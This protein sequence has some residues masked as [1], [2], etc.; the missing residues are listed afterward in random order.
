MPP[1]I[2]WI[3]L[4]P[5][6]Q[7]RQ[8]FRKYGRHTHTHIQMHTHAHFLASLLQEYTVLKVAFNL[9]SWIII[10]LPQ[11]LECPPKNVKCTGWSCAK[12]VIR[13]WAPPCT[14]TSASHWII[15]LE[16]LQLLHME[17]NYQR[18]IQTSPSWSTTQAFLYAI[19]NPCIHEKQSETIKRLVST[20][21]EIIY[22]YWHFYTDCLRLLAA[23][24]A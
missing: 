10:T 12:L 7:I 23:S 15:K 19:Y 2:S 17:W 16:K 8:D 5:P 24:W 21:F 6:C 9:I 14:I 11:K 20:Y 1:L 4:P 3:I 22:G 18:P 13:S